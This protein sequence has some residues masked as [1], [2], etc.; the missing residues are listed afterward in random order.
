[1]SVLGSTQGTGKYKSLQTLIIQ[2]FTL[3]TKQNVKHLAD[4]YNP[5]GFRQEVISVW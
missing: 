5:I 2:R 1:M 4:I 3:D